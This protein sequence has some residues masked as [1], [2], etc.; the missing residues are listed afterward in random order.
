MQIMPRRF[1]PT[2]VC[3]HHTFQSFRLQKGFTRGAA[4]HE[5]TK[6]AWLEKCMVHFCGSAFHQ[7]DLPDLHQ[8]GAITSIP[9]F[10]SGPT[11][12]IK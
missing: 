7:G 6:A 12:T 5:C 2:T 4:F 9:V 10:C 3:L 11:V 8:H 1:Q